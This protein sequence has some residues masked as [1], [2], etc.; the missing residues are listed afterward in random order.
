MTI[1]TWMIYGAAGY[2]GRLITEKAVEQGLKPVLAGRNADHI[3]EIAAELCLQHR[4]FSLHGDDDIAVHLQ[5]IDAV[6]S[7]AGPFSSTAR[8]MIDACIRAGTHY[9]DITGEL[10][11]FEHAHS[12]EID[13]AARAAGVTICPGIGF[14]V[15]PTDC[16]ARALVEEMP[17]AT[18]LQLGFSG[19]MAVSPGT[20]KSMIEGLAVGTKARRHGEIV[21][22]PLELGD[23]DYGKGPQ[24]SM[25]VS[26]GDVSTAYHTTGIGNITVSWPASNKDIR[27]ARMAGYFRPLLRLKRVQDYLKKQVD[28]RVTGPGAQ[29]RDR[30]PV[31]VWGE[32]KNAAGEMVTA[33]IQTANGYSVTQDAPVLIVQHMLEHELPSGSHTPA[34]LFGKDF[35]STVPGS[36]QIEI[37]KGGQP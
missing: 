2:S 34:R 37:T 3:R 32:A 14:D 19:D 10:N 26:W 5:G 24:Q 6:I 7:T 15:I 35:I 31:M 29:Q 4:E 9:F 8:P 33:R 12:R 23:I 21:T 28:K 1:K 13:E 36:S 25:S 22:I 16:I 27:Q 20:A 18:D 17:D 11:V 30:S